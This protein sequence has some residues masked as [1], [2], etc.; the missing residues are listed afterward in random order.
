MA[1]SR[2]QSRNDIFLFL[3]DLQY[4]KLLADFLQKSSPRHRYIIIYYSLQVWPTEKEQAWHTASFDPKNAFIKKEVKHISDWN[5]LK[6]S[7]F[8][9][10]S[11]QGKKL[12]INFF[13]FFL[14]FMKS[15]Q[16]SAFLNE[17]TMLHFAH[18][19]YLYI[20]A[21]PIFKALSA[22]DPTQFSLLIISSGWQ[23][24]STLKNKTKCN[25]ILAFLNKSRRSNLYQS[26]E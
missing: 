22:S 7:N 4:Y 2:L 26:T 19:F 6:I 17:I 1:K 10:K 18:A 15:F 14:Q 20:S 21:S 13:F 25:I 24:W 12:D 9:Q 5:G 16:R 8:I 23:W 3:A 11:V